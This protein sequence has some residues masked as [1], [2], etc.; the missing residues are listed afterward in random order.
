MQERDKAKENSQDKLNLFKNS[1]SPPLPKKLEAKTFPAKPH[2]TSE[3]PKITR[4]SKESNQIEAEEEAP[5]APAKKEVR[6]SM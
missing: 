5:L 3:Q 6:P 4:N 1:A 2:N